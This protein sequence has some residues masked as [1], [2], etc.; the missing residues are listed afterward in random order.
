MQDPS[1]TEFYIGSLESRAFKSGGWSPVEF[2]TESM[3]RDRYEE[4]IARYLIKTLD[5]EYELAETDIKEGVAKCQ[6]KHDTKT[7]LDD[8]DISKLHVRFIRKIGGR[9]Y[10]HSVLPFPF[11]LYQRHF[12][13]LVAYRPEYS[14]YY[15]CIADLNDNKLAIKGQIIF[16]GSGKQIAP[17]HPQSE[18]N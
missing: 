17:R 4:D 18:R 12:K 3:I 6:L 11:K 7:M 5:G 13:T 10:T 1:R 2:Y 8:N 9:I 15:N 14:I 16:D